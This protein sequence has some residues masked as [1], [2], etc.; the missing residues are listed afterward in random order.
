MS[1]SN[2]VTPAV[3]VYEIPV[4]LW[5]GL[6]ALAIV[7]LAVTGYLI[8]APLAS[9]SGEASDHYVMGYIRFAHFAAGYVLVIALV[10]RVYWAYA[11]NEH[12]RQIFL[13]PLLSS[14]SKVF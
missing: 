13:P 4:R 2:A 10:F 5:H 9:V 7:V 3:Y 6:N 1:E 11:G 14:C 8:A 12:A